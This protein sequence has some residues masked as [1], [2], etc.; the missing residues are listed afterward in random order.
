MRS[1]QDPKKRKLIDKKP[2]VTSQDPDFPVSLLSAAV[3]D[4]GDNKPLRDSI[5]MYDN[6]P[7]MVVL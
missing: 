3:V 1:I 4:G 2:V 7:F 5:A 6:L